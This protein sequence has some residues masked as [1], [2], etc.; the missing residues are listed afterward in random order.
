MLIDREAWGRAPSDAEKGSAAQRPS[1]GCP[2]P[3]PSLSFLCWVGCGALRV[4]RRPHAATRLPNGRRPAQAGPHT[5]P[6]A[7]PAQRLNPDRN[8][9]TPGLNRS[10]LKAQFS[11]HRGA[12]RTRGRP[13]ESEMRVGGGS[14]AQGKSPATREPLPPLC[15]AGFNA[16]SHGHG[17]QARCGRGSAWILRFG[18]WT[19][20][21]GRPNGASSRQRRG[22]RASPVQ[23]PPRLQRASVPRGSELPPKTR[24]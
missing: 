8:I 5:P 19:L 20:T 14:G 22:R 7:F 10:R 15:K 16:A 12:W 23:A 11:P 17:I 18:V 21:S 6:H 9:S 4:R 24:L 2:L 13:Q 1:L 3:G